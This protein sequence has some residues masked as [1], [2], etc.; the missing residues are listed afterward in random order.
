M[1]NPP[2]LR[3]CIEEMQKKAGTYSNMNEYYAS[4]AIRSG[5]KEDMEM[6]KLQIAK[7]DTAK[8]LLD[9]LISIVKINWPEPPVEN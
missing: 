4:T 9:E 3:K 1:I 8:Q 2:K 6:A 5:R 7:S